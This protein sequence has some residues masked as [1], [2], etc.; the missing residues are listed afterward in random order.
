MYLRNLLEL[1]NS[2]IKAKLI[3]WFKFLLQGIKIMLFIKNFWKG[4]KLFLLFILL[5][6]VFRSAVADWYTVPTGSMQP[7]IKEGDRIIVNKMAYDIKFPFSQ[8]SLYKV[9]EPKRGEIVVFESKAAQNRLIKRLIGLPGDVIEMRDEAL[10]IN[11][12]PLNYQISEQSAQQLL[13]TEQVDTI[14]HHVRIDKQRSNQLSNFKPITVPKGH[15]LVLGDNRRHS[16]DS[17]VCFSRFQQAF[18]ENRCVRRHIAR[19]FFLLTCDHVKLANTVTF[20]ARS[21]GGGVALAF[22]GHRM[23]QDGAFA[24]IAHIAQHGDQLVH[25]MTVDRAH[26]AEAHFLEQGAAHGHAAQIF[27]GPARVLLHAQRLGDAAPEL[28]DGVIAFRA[29]LTS[30]VMAHRAHGR[31]DGHV[32]VI[33]DDNEI[34]LHVP[35]IVHGLIGH[36]CGHGA[37]ADHRDDLAAF[38]MLEVAPHGKA[39]A[40]RDRGR[41]VRGAER[42]V[43]AFRTLGEAGQAAALA[44]GAYAVAPPGQDLVRI[45]LMADVPHQAVARRIKDVVKGNGKLKHAQAG[46]EMTAGLAH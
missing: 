14:I 30:E 3:D 43:V 18:G 23:D 4:N 46:P 13:V 44:Q 20:V 6:S 17:R 38:F 7:T 29:D 19:R 27:L 11:G 12:K 25:V 33:E 41:G 28:A 42:V 32:I 21:L 31:G 22:L 26:I 8:L 36:P 10:F 24:R 1:V 5:M 16:A 37:V 34:F 15:Y 9:S 40:R 39:Q 2:I 45:G 35:G